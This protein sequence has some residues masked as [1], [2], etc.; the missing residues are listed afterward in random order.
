MQNQLD[1]QA[2]ALS[3]A[4]RQT[5]SGG[6]W[7]AKG[8]S[9]EFGAYQFTAPTWSAYSKEF[10]VN[11]A[12]GSATPD[13]QN[14]VAYKKIKQW[15]DAGYN[16]GQIASM[17]NAGPGKPNAYVEGHKGVN[18]QGV[19]YDTP[20]Y[21]KRV[22]RAYQNLKGQQFA[23]QQQD[24]TIPGQERSFIQDAG[25]SLGEAGTKLST[26]IGRAA[27]GEINP[28][29]GI[30]QSAGAVAGGV[31]DLT[32]DTL[33]H[34]PVVGEAVKGLEK[35]VGKG[36][37]K[38]AETET[39]QNV[40]G[41][42]QKL[43]QNVRD[44]IG[45]GAEIASA[46]PV[47]KGL[48]AVKNMAKGGLRTALKG[49]TDDVLEAVAKDLGPKARSKAVLQRGTEKKGL[50][51]EVR[52]K[53]DA[54][55]V[56][57]ADAV[58]RNV[59]KFDPSKP[60]ENIHETQQ[61]VSKMSKDLKT[62]VKAEAGD[63]IYP[64]RELVSRLRNIERPDLLASD[65]VL[66]GAYNRLINRLES[67]LT[68]RPGKVDDLLDLRKEFDDIVKKQYPDLYAS[69]RLTPIRQAIGDI[70]EEITRFTA[71]NLP[72]GAGF[73]DSLL[74]QHKL[75]KAMENIAEKATKGSG[76]EIGS[77][78]LSRFGD[79]HPIVKGLL[80]TGGRMFAEGTGIGTVMK[81][82]D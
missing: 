50:L 80:K 12:F 24:A 44:N 23:T 35:V 20:E 7:N 43:P 3:K 18:S 29:S 21:A 31:N 71:E 25:A 70:R 47:L 14:E 46:I 33:H 17:W 30:L 62:K 53:P 67:M 15:K 39:G 69:E 72:D 22:A 65:A 41:A 19:E 16:P 55:E 34:I 74:T 68:K 51:G 58:R 48:G 57:I 76:Q 5:E 56:D 82:M 28:V 9:G 10:G 1:P 73:R 38:V 2:V 45:A 11:A 6:D 54:R 4:I 37:Q 63:R 60:L 32:A 78:A 26:A 49:S 40:I 52:I 61:V 66:D 36:A 79:N 64:K 13:Q 59:P 27:G 42:Y 8:K 77:N 75:L 81:I